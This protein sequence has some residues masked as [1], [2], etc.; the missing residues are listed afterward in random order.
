MQSTRLCSVAEC[1]KPHDSHGYCAM[2]AARFRRVR[3]IH[4]GRKTRQEFFSAHIN[5]DPSGCWLWTAKIGRNGYGRYAEAELAHRVAY[6]LWKGPIPAGLEIDHLCM[7]KHCVNPDH[8]EAV[9]HAENLRRRDLIY[10]IR[11]A[12][13]ECPHGHPY[14]S[15]N[16]YLSP[17]GRRQCRECA[18]IRAARNRA[19]GK[20]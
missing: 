11:T 13:T 17:S 3:P 19:K 6:E 8:L 14:D 18:R 15:T 1:G 7:V 16:T 4:Q 5:R 9:T 12:V 20:K 10:G 2:H